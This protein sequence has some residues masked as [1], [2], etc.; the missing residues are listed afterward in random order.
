MG[1]ATVVPRRPKAKGTSVTEN[2]RFSGFGE[3]NCRHPTN[4]QLEPVSGLMSLKCSAV[5]SISSARDRRAATLSVM[6]YT[7]RI[8]NGM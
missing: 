8:A 3:W 1:V 5:T 7:A 2:E 6:I 4:P